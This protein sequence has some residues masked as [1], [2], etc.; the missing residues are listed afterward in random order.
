MNLDER[1]KAI[2]Q[3]LMDLFNK[4]KAKYSRSVTQI[5]MMVPGA[6]PEMAVQMRIG[7]CMSRFTEMNG[8]VPSKDLRSTVEDMVVY[9]TVWLAMLP[10]EASDESAPAPAERSRTE[11]PVYAYMKRGPHR[12]P[13]QQKEF[14][15]LAL[16]G[17]YSNIMDAA[18]ALGVNYYTLRRW[19]NVYTKEEL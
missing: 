11:T 18:K 7:D 2:N 9:W 14:V 10:E 1:V 13:E 19:C 12:T 4:N 15:R 5:T 8:K 16:N 17:N 3:N 6:P